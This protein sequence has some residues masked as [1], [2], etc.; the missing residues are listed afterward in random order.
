MQFI[1]VDILYK[2]HFILRRK[3]SVQSPDQFIIADPVLQTAPFPPSSADRSAL[4]PPPVARK[5]GSVCSLF[6]SYAKNVAVILSAWYFYCCGIILML[7]QL[8]K[9]FTKACFSGKA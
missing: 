8:L 3:I 4:L 9:P 2:L 6:Y 1:Q 5:N 7:R